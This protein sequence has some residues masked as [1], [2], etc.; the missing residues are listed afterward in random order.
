MC[1]CGKKSARFEWESDVSHPLAS[2]TA[3]PPDAG[4]KAKALEAT[5]NDVCKKVEIGNL[6]RTAD[7]RLALEDARL[8]TAKARGVDCV[9]VDVTSPQHLFDNL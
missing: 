7:T 2:S 8:L 3:S 6:C 1:G 5:R 4:L 9:I